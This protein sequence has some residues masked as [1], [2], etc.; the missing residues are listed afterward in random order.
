MQFNETPW[1]DV[2]LDAKGFTVFKDKYPVTEGHILFVPKEES[3][4]SLT[5]CFEAAYKWG[6]DWVER[7][8]CDAFNVGQNVGEEAGQTVMYPHIHLIPRRKGDMAD[9]KGGVRGVIPDMQKYTITN[10]K[11]PDLFLEGDCV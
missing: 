7:G 11:Q 4:K 10:S 2:L 6:Y 8:Y 9:P 3:W 1:N 5:K